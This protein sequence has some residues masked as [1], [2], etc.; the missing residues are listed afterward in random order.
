MFHAQWTVDKRLVGQALR[1]V[2]LNFPHFSNHDAAHSQT[3][4]QRIERVLG[5][6]RIRK[7][8]PTT[9]WM[10]LSAA[11]YHDSGMIVS[12]TEA[13]RWWR[14]DKEFRSMVLLAQANADDP[15]HREAVMLARQELD[16]EEWPLEVRRA[17]TLLVAEFARGKHSDRSGEF[18]KDPGAGPRRSRPWPE[19]DAEALA[20]FGVGS[21][22]PE[23]HETVGRR[24][25]G[26]RERTQGSVHGFVSLR[27]GAH[28]LLL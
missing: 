4:I 11:Y 17:I 21:V 10:L 8:S 24:G 13:R 28:T 2:P 12:D 5:A 20:V 25:A 1:A 9:T 14:E 22:L 18:V 19:R 7:L 23:S 15:L 6:A 27:S 3:I 26:R 16:G